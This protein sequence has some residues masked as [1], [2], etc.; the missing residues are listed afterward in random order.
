MP[1]L[2]SHAHL[3][4]VIFN[5]IPK[6]QQPAFLTASQQQFAIKLSEIE[7][8]WKTSSTFGSGTGHGGGGKRGG[9]GGGQPGGG[10]GKRGGG[11]GGSKRGDGGNGNRGGKAGDNGDGKAGD[12][13]DGRAGNKIGRKR[14]RHND[15][16]IDGKAEI[17]G[18]NGSQVQG[19]DTGDKSLRG[20]RGDHKDVQ[21]AYL[22]TPVSTLHRDSGDFAI[23]AS[24]GE[25]PDDQKKVVLDWREQVVK[26]GPSE[27]AGVH[28]KVR[29]HRPHRQD[30]DDWEPTNLLADRSNFTSNDWAVYWMSF[31][32]PCRVLRKTSHM[33]GFPDDQV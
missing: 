2:E 7:A 27:P 31:N 18:K 23:G 20:S 10:H 5:A 4:Y 15:N 33:T 26:A 12:N 11:Q 25:F 14:Q 30:W 28:W 8:L 16:I 9:G 22:P 29:K 32:L 24:V 3:F 6:F 13:G 17:A 19:E 1:L 21:R